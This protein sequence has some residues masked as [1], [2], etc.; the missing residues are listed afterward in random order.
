MHQSRHLSC[1][2]SEGEWFALPSDLLPKSQLTNPCVVSNERPFD[3]AKTH[4]PAEYRARYWSNSRIVDSSFQ[5]ATNTLYQPGLETINGIAQKPRQRL[6]SGSKLESTFFAHCHHAQVEV[7]VVHYTQSGSC[8]P[9]CEQLTVIHVLVNLLGRCVG[10]HR[11]R[12]NLAT[13]WMPYCWLIFTYHSRGLYTLLSGLSQTGRS[14]PL[15][16]TPTELPIN[17]AQY[18]WVPLV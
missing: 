10:A 17:A 13:Y 14:V 6:Q 12:A 2:A 3:A 18:R 11:T 8:H 16:S 4:V 9:E 1:N 5:D 15:L 7:V